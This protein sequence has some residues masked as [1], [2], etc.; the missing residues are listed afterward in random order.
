MPSHG[1]GHWFDPSIAHSCDLDRGPRNC[2]LR[3]TWRESSQDHVP[4]ECPGCAGG[5][6]ARAHRSRALPP[7]KHPVAPPTPRWVTRAQLAERVHK[8]TRTIDTWIATGRIKAYRLPGGRS[9]VID[10]NEVDELNP[11]RRASRAGVGMITPQAAPG[12]PK[13]R[14]GQGRQRRD[15]H[16]SSRTEYNARYS[17]SWPGTPRCSSTSAP[18]T[19]PRRSSA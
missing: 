2:W 18:N 8:S 4:R 13:P 6:R 12:R 3:S 11:L 5:R 16:G 15:D 17:T 9:L 19:W 1:R 14:P 7:K 10:L